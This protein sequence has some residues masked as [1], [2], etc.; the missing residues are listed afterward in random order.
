MANSGLRRAASL[1]LLAVLCGCGHRQLPPDLLRVSTGAEGDVGP[2][3]VR[4]VM[5][6]HRTSGYRPGADVPV[7]ATVVNGGATPDRLVAVRTPLAPEVVV[8]G[9]TA[10]PPE[11]TVH[12]AYPN[13]PAGADAALIE[14][15][16]RDLRA[17]L[18]PGM[19]YPVEFRFARAGAVRL[20][21][22]T[23]HALAP[24]PECP[25]PPNGTP[26]ETYHAPLDAPH[27]PTPTPPDCSSLP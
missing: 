15:R 19:T 25:L 23:D 20:E 9:D 21:V 24:R 17:P 8:R 4:E 26:L 13:Q 6:A 7:L 10:L 18:R 3:A 16:L 11:G 22:T 5:F 1:V 27:P 12:T 14:I 2:I